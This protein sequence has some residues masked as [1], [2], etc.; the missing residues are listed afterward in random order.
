MCECVTPACIRIKLRKLY[1]T[2]VD[3]LVPSCLYQRQDTIL[4]HI[5]MSV[6]ALLLAACIRIKLC[7]LYTTDVNALLAGGLYVCVCV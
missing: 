5:C 3:A 7:K 4:I 1:T 6:H 2:D